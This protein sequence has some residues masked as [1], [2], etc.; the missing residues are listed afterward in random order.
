MQA[1]AT[2]LDAPA[3]FTDVLHDGG[4]APLLAAL[5]NIQK[6]FTPASVG[7]WQACD[8]GPAT[9][10]PICG[11]LF[12][13][14]FNPSMSGQP[15][16]TD[17]STGAG[18]AAQIA[19]ASTNFRRNHLYGYAQDG[20]WTVTGENLDKVQRPPIHTYRV[21][22]AF[23]SYWTGELL[24]FWKSGRPAS[25]GT[26]TPFDTIY[27]QGLTRLAAQEGAHPGISRHFLPSL[28]ADE[29]TGLLVLTHN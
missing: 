10:P 25:V 12:F 1:L 28:V 24:N 3:I 15:D 18:L 26:V 17:T 13:F 4:P 5:G 23:T 27:R 11:P 16:F 2:I 21:D 19:R 14:D 20:V 7:P 8:G 29:T 9:T 6:F 22:L